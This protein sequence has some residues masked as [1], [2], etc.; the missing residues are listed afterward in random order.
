[1]TVSGGYNNTVIGNCSF[2][3]SNNSVI[4]GDGIAVIGGQ[5]ITGSTNNTVYVP[6][7]NIQTI[8]TGTSISNLGID[9]SGNVI[10]GQD[11][12]GS[13]ALYE[14]GSGADSTQRIDTSNSAVGTCSLVSGGFGNT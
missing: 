11:L 9:S 8:T 10:F 14:V 13:T 2:A 1:S 3:V 5:N 7:L 6:S 4:V 12:T